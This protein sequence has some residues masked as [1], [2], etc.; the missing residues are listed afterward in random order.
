MYCIL[1]GFKS[2]AKDLVQDKD[3]ASVLNLT[4]QTEDCRGWQ[5][6]GRGANFS[7]APTSD[8]LIQDASNHFTCRSLDRVADKDKSKYSKSLLVTKY[9]KMMS[10]LK[11]VMHY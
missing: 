4:W 7:L 6:R 5:I 1:S 11:N 10:L 9:I 2:E 3:F 8:I